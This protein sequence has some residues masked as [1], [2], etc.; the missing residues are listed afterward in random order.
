MDPLQVEPDHVE[1]LQ[2]EPDQ[3]EPDQVEPDQVEPLQV[4]PDH[5]DPLQVDPD[6]VEPL[7]TPPFQALLLSSAAAM[8]A[9]DQVLPKMSCSPLSVTPPRATWLDPRA[10]SRE[11]L[12]LLAG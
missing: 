1:P 4:L 6:Q 2:V 11:P 10:P 5:V 9:D 7:K 12:P 8:A 3:V